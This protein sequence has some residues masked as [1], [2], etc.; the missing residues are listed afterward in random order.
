MLSIFPLCLWAMCMSCLEKCLFKYFAHFL[1]EF[2]VFLASGF[3]SF[4]YILE[5]KFLSDISLA[6]IFSHIVVTLFFLL[7]VSLAVQ[8]LFNFM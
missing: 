5:I 3:I 1:I 6:K 8:K 7:M 4:L 2:F